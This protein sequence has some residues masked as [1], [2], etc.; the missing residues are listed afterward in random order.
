MPPARAAAGNSSNTGAPLPAP[1]SVPRPQCRHLP[2]FEFIF[3]CLYL[4]VAASPCTV[5]HDLRDSQDVSQRHTSLPSRGRQWSRIMFGRNRAPGRRPCPCAG[6]VSPWLRE[7]HPWYG[8]STRHCKYE[9]CFNY[10]IHGTLLFFLDFLLK[11]LSVHP[12]K[13]N[14]G[15]TP[16]SMKVKDT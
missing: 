11:I 15:M 9:R 12:L 2:L 3:L 13:H 7:G 5:T 16:R 6:A 4:L 1:A 14:I 8:I 10:R